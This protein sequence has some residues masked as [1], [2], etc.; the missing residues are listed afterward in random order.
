MIKDFRALVDNTQDT[1][2]HAAIYSG[3]PAF[4]KNKRCNKTYKSDE[5]LPAME[6]CIYHGIKVEVEGLEG[7]YISQI[8]QCTGSQRWHG[9]D[10]RNNQV[11]VIQFPGR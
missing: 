1:T 5:Q 2:H 7:E 8:C 3:T 6:L 10:R 9:G 11:W 4:M